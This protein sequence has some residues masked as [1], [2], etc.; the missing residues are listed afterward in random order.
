MGISVSAS[1]AVVFLGMFIAAGVLYPAVH[2][3]GEQMLD[4]REASSDDSLAQTNTE[5]DLFRADYYPDN[6]TLFVNATNTGTTTLDLP[7]VN[8]LVD[9]DPQSDQ[10]S[11]TSAIA[12]DTGTELW[13]PGED[14]GFQIKGLTSA[15]DRIKLI[16]DY[17]VS[18]ASSVVVK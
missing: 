2:N 1:T 8:V 18:E 9:N 10:S 11:Y 3:G 15:P 6:D 7:E 17:G 14:A 12:G 4:A 16:V 13:L 5:I